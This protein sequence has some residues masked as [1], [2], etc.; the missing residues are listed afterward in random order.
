MGYQLFD[1]GHEVETE[2]DWQSAFEPNRMFV[3]ANKEVHGLIHDEKYNKG[4]MSLNLAI[5][6][7]YFN[8]GYDEVEGPVTVDITSTDNDW[9]I[10]LEERPDWS[11][12]QG[13]P[14]NTA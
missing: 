7:K 13:Y 5:N 2:Y 6:E 11:R 14:E 9:D 12:E 8:E 3:P 1:G 4:D 10:T